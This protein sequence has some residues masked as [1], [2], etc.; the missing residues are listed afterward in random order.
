MQII[1]TNFKRNYIPTNLHAL[2]TI[3]IKS[4][5]KQ[6]NICLLMAFFTYTIWL[7]RS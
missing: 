2:N 1:C 3:H 7:K 6:K 4:L 5:F